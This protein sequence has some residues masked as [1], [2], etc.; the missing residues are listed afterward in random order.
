MSFNSKAYL[1]YQERL[2]EPDNLLLRGNGK[3]YKPLKSNPATIDPSDAEK[4]LQMQR[5]KFDNAY[6]DADAAKQDEYL[7]QFGI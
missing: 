4:L 3:R 1:E 5:M 6:Q 2:L 7:K